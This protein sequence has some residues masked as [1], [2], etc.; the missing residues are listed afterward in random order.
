MALRAGALRDAKGAESGDRKEAGRVVLGGLLLLEEEADEEAAGC[1]LVVV[2][3]VGGDEAAD[4][5]VI[6]DA[7]GA[8]GIERVVET[9]VAS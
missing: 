2:G 4:V 3:V 8:L 9:G 1:G 5:P 7:V 6:R